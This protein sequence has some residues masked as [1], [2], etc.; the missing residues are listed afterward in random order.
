MGLNVSYHNLVSLVRIKQSLCT[1]ATSG[2]LC[3]S[4]QSFVLNKWASAS[5]PSLPEN[6]GLKYDQFNCGCI[7][8][9]IWT[10]GA[11]GNIGLS[12]GAGGSCGCIRYSAWTGGFCGCVS[13]MCAGGAGAG[14][15]CGL[16]G[17]GS[18]TWSGGTSVYG[19]SWGWG[20]AC[21]GS[22]VLVF[23]GLHAVGSFGVG[24]PLY[25]ISVSAELV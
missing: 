7:Q 19:S 15:S 23:A 21:G 9:G 4:T 17:A 13:G 16:G 20:A 14:E 1:F 10:I 5:S 2:K 22:P 25:A 12:T 11:G 6:S 18:G 24:G 8:F 3:V